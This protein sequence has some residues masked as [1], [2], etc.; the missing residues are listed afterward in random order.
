[1]KRKSLILIIASIILISQNI[2]GQINN[3]MPVN[4]QDSLELIELYNSTDGPNWTKSYQW[5]SSSYPIYL[6]Y[7]VDPDE[8]RVIKV[9]LYN[10]NLSGSVP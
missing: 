10:N 4:N 8:D 6:W 1:M 7:G 3:G 2:V 9:E 5:L